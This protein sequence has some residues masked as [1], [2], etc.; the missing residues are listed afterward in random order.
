MK[1]AAALGAFALAALSSGQLQAQSPLMAAP[2]AAAPPASAPAAPPTADEKR[3]ETLFNAAKQLR[4]GGQLAEACPMFAESKR[5]AP[6]IG[7]TLHLGDCYERMGRPASAW[8][9]YREAEN[10]ARQKRD[11]KRADLAHQRAHAL[12]SKVGRLTLAASTGPHDGWQV[13]I[14]GKT[15][16]P[17]MWNTAV[18]VDPVDHTVTVAAPGKP[19][20]TLTAHLDATTA[21][22]LVNID[23]SDGAGAPAVAA[24]PVG[25]ASEPASPPADATPPD[26]STASHTDTRRIWAEVALAGV[27]AVG[28]GLGAAFLVKKNQSMS[29]GNACDGP[30]EDKQAATAST[31]AFAIG[32]IALASAVVVY[33]TTPGHQ[34]QVGVT[35]SPAVMWGGGGAVVRSSF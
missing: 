20:R 23:G 33:L 32:G 17:E 18:A 16:P 19:L 29:E 2:P 13:Q 24:V 26:A 5:L 7:V 34:N 12:E 27:G 9:Q 3:A 14:D 6:G 11:D 4:D 1:Q 30:S 25:A 15:V 21:A 28:L 22:A 10:L 35:V 31:V 8:E